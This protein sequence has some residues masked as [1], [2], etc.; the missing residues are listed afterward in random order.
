MFARKSYC[1]CLWL[2]EKVTYSWLPVL[3]KEVI[4]FQFS[5]QSLLKLLFWIE[6][7]ENYINNSIK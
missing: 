6:L 5:Q 7:N 2:I 3:N 1:I 4:C